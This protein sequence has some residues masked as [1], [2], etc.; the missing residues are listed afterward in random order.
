MGD[1]IFFP[2]FAHPSVLQKG[3]LAVRFL[4]SP[5]LF[6]FEERRDE[7]LP[8]LHPY[9]LMTLEIPFFASGA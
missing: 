4:I 3:V 8:P 2:G 6:F 9:A 7:A 1:T 5:L